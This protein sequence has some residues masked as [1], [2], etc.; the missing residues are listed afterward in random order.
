MGFDLRKTVTEIFNQIMEK[1][2]EN[3][4]ELDRVHR[5][6]TTS[7]I[8]HAKPHDVFCRVHFFRTREDIIRATWQK[9]PAVNNGAKIQIYPDLCPQTNVTC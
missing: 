7:N 3:L 4:I 5:V 9:G 1:P 2:L 8:D 6:P